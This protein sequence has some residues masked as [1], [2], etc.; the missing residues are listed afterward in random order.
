MSK[1]RA[2]DAA[3]TGAELAMAV[4][5]KAGQAHAQQ[6][7]KRGNR[8]PTGDS[9]KRSAGRALSDL[10]D[11]EAEVEASRTVVSAPTPAEIR[12]AGGQLKKIRKMSARQ[13][14]TKA[15]IKALKDGIETARKLKKGVQL[16]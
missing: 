7:R 15:G 5:R 13:A 9:V 1:K 11:F 2:R 16:S 6:R 14:A 3:E 4:R 10:E 8:K 12:E